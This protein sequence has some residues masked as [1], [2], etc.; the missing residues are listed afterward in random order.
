MGR[1]R[2]GDE[3]E[4]RGS[5]KVLGCACLLLAS[6]SGARGWR[7]QMRTLRLNPVCAGTLQLERSLCFACVGVE[8]RWVCRGKTLWVAL[9]GVGWALLCGSEL[10]ARM[11]QVGI[12][13]CSIMSPD[14]S[15]DKATY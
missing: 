10:S 13:M 3:T 1:V 15:V 6:D 7:R 4:R 5:R 2:A 8:R 11:I 12:A 9:E 14:I